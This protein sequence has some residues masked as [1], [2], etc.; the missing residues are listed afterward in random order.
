[1]TATETNSPIV[2]NY[3]MRTAASG[4]NYIRA[5]AL[6][7]SGITHDA[8][9]VLPHPIYVSRAER[10][11]KWDVDGN[12][13]VDYQGGHGAL[14]LGHRHPKVMEAVT[15]QLQKG[16]HYG[17]GS[18]LELQWADLVKQLIPSAERVRFTSSGTEA[19]MMALRL[20]RAATG[21]SKLIRFRGH[22]H[23]WNDNMAFGY[24][25]HFDGSPSP[26]VLP[27]VAESVL[28]ADPNDLSGVRDVMDQ[29]EI[30]AVILEPTGS[31][32][33]QVPIEPSFLR[34]LRDLTRS[35]G[36]ILIFDEVVSG[37]RVSPGGAQSELGIIPD[38]TT[39][40]KILAGGL[41]GGA[42]VG[43]KDILDHLDHASA[44]AAGRDRI[45]H[46]GTFNANP[47]SAAAGCATLELIR[48]TDVCQRANAYA[49][50]LRT[51]MNQLLMDEGVAWS[52]YGTYSGF[53]IFTNAANVDVD[54]RSFDPLK[55]DYLTLKGKRGTS[56]A[57]KLRLAMRVN[58]V[59]L[60]GWPGGPVSAA[61]DAQDLDH[62]L[63]AF[64]QSI[65]S[66]KE[67]REI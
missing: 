1:M 7:P 13:Y 14:L 33:G 55:H 12:E 37:F 22:F 28:L 41:P 50:R 30:A 3:R 52:V 61:H 10:G 35:R 51:E 57:T 26:G 67:E 4:E 56:L 59:D 24:S 2:T 42:V 5:G 62:T 43:R 20:A 18:E 17:A 15:E 47:L 8:R 39:L 23:G 21:R 6:F 48:D 46:P 58:G 38:L 19:T 25:D 54:P 40:A 34:S 16:T 32:F 64:R 11:R 44:A 27:S 29:H 31:T 66:L 45:Q 53:H 36:V 63:Q 65:R 60:S 49:Q 9:Y